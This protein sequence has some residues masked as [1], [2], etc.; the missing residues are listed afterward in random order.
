MAHLA[1]ESNEVLD[2]ELCRQTPIP[3]PE[4]ASA[5]RPAQANRPNEPAALSRSARRAKAQAALRD[6]PTLRD[7]DFATTR[8]F[9]LARRALP[10]R[11]VAFVDLRDEAALDLAGDLRA[12]LL[13]FLAIS[14]VPLLSL[15]S[16][17]RKR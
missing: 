12:D 15:L 4:M 11:F 16:L 17:D 8:F 14:S 3:R 5:G 7:E 9:R 2:L 6:L 13:D 10:A 1:G